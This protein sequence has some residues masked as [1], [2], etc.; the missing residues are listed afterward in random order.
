MAVNK[1][2]ASVEE[3]VADVHDGAV[4]L[5]GGFG[6][7]VTVPSCLLTALSKLPV[8]NLTV[9]S[10]SGGF[11]IEIWGEHDV[12]V[13]HRTGQCKKHIVS[14]PVNPLVVNTLEKRV[15]AGEVEIEMVPQGTM[16][17]RIRCARAGLGGVLT[18]TGVGIPEIEKGKQVIE[19]DGRKYLVEIAIKAD[20]ALIRAHKADRWGNLVYRG[21]S[22]TFNATMAGAAKVTIA[23]VDEIVELGELNPE[24]IITPGVYVNRVVLR[25]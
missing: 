5:V 1:I 19:V 4:I 18:P 25:S 10:N 13:L 24:H 8:S 12:E 15:R 6:N 20:F 11:G 17:E 2:V 23:E 14:A 21:T 3:A 7:I 16:A 9:V 22:R